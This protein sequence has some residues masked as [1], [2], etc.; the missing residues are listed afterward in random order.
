[1]SK[2]STGEVVIVVVD[3]LTGELLAAGTSADLAEANEEDELF[4][5]ALR[6]LRDGER[7]IINVPAHCGSCFMYRVDWQARQVSA[8]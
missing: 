7:D 8:R 3:S 6:Q 1:M 2:Q 4:V 5:K